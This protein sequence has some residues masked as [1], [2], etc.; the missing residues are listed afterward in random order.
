VSSKMSSSIWITKYLSVLHQW[1]VCNTPSYYLPQSS[2]RQVF[3][4]QH[5]CHHCLVHVLPPL[6]FVSSD[7]A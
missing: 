6:Y 2:T 3:H 4:S 1:K 7:D 5:L